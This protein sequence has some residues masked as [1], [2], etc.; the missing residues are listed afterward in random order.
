MKYEDILYKALLFHHYS[1]DKATRPLVT[2][3]LPPVLQPV[4]VLSK[5][6]FYNNTGFWPD[7]FQKIMN[8]LKLIPNTIIHYETEYKATKELSLCIL[9]NT[10]TLC[11]H[12]FFILQSSLCTIFHKFLKK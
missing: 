2:F 9:L 10:C 6:D 7:Q 8:E 12:E 4:E 1:Y 11:M 5:Y 3:D